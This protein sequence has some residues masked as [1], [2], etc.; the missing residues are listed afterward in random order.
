MNTTGRFRG[1]SSV[2]VVALAVRL[3][4]L[5]ALGHGIPAAIGVTA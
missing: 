3:P 4:G 5:L 2:L 1:T